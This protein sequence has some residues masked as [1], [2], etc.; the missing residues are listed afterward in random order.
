MNVSPQW[1]AWRDRARA[2]SIQGIASDRKIG[3]KRQ[4]RERIGAC[5]RCGDRFAINVEKECFNSRGCKA[6]AAVIALVSFFKSACQELTGEPPPGGS[7]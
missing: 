3:L 7:A 2:T 6:K 4:G 5:P 1:K